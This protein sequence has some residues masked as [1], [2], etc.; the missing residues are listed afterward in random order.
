MTLRFLTTTRGFIASGARS[1]LRARW[2][3][4]LQFIGIA[5]LIAAGLLWTRIPEKNAWQ[6]A[7]TLIVPALVAAGFLALQTGYLRSLLRSAEPAPESERPAVAF[8]L[9]ALTLLLWIAI[10][11]VLWN[12]I[13]IFD[14]NTDDWASYLNSKLDSGLRARI[15]TYTHLLKWLSYA[16]WF[17]RWVIV[18]GLLIPFGSTALFG[19]RR[20]PWGRI[21]RVW[22][23]WRWWPVVLGL[24]LLGQELPQKFF[25]FDPSGTVNAQITRVIFKVIAAYLL[26]VLCWVIALAWAAALIMGPPGEAP[27]LTEATPDPNRLEGRPLPVGNAED[28][29]SGNA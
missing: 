29:L 10:G 12:L 7:L 20:A 23:N 28:H 9:G 3:V 25:E 26:A 22:I 27:A 24:A 13:D 16:A 5:L 17:L 15:F 14:A 18:P 6:V 8:A 19:M 4:A 21:L 1:V 2:W 11:W